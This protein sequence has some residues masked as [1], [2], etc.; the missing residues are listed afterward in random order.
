[1]VH[2]FHIRF[3]DGSEQCFGVENESAKG[4]DDLLYVDII[5]D[6]FLSG[7]VEVLV[8]AIVKEDIREMENSK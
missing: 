8:H 3:V 2:D 6:D 5:F 1:M 4:N 7:I